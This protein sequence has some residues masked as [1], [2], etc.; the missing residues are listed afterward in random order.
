MKKQFFVAAMILA[1]GAGFTA[2][3]SDDLNVKE[4]KE[5]ANKA[6]SYMTVSFSL[7]TAGATRAAADGQDKDNPDFNNVGTWEGNDKIEKV[8]VY[9]FKADGTR[10]TKQTFNNSDLGIITDSNGK[11]IVTPNKAFKVEAGN[12]TVYVVVNPTTASETLL[13]NVQAEAGGTVKDAFKKAYESDKLAFTASTTADA[14]SSAAATFKT[15]AEEVAKVDGGKDVI[16]M[17]GLSADQNIA[18]NVSQA[19]AVSGQKNRVPVTVQRVASRVFVTTS[20]ASFDVKG[21][22]PETNAEAVVASVG[23]LNYSVAQG[24]AS[25]YFLQKNDAGQIKSP[26]YDQKLT[27]GDDY[28]D[29]TYMTA[30]KG[31]TK[32]YDYSGLWKKSTVATLSAY[33][34]T[35]AAKLKNVTDNQKAGLNGAFILPALHAYNTDRTQSGYQA[36]NTA[37]IIVR[38]TLTVKRYVDADGHAASDLAKGTT[39]YLGANG[40]F[41]TSATQVVDATKGG[42]PGQTAR[43]FDGG[44][45]LYI[46]YV[47]PDNVSKAVN[48]PVIRNQ[49]YHVHIKDITKVGENWNPLVPNQTTPSTDNPTPPN[50]NNPDDFP[51]GNPNEPKQPNIKP[52]DPLSQKE[53]WMAV[54]VTILPWQ[55]HSVEVTL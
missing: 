25:L 14:T 52:S 53:T 44:K 35:D 37:Y 46:L 21:V 49:V 19:Q 26:A 2:C 55:V 15:R 7:P 45:V 23:D 8:N 43:K 32:Y 3:S 11:T 12:K 38:G 10:E 51:K 34:A 48:G 17:T 54:N 27:A 13:D 39:V 28:W 30:Y 42:V 24:E 50:P 36:G 1:L 20:A 33:G 18:D 4:Q 6:T 47:N 29:A 22:D 31:M 9:V 40:K 41:Y 16:M 5:V